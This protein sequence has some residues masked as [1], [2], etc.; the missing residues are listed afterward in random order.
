MAF[1][2]FYPEFWIYDLIQKHLISTIFTSLLMLMMAAKES[3]ANYDTISLHYKSWTSN[4]GG[5]VA[6]SLKWAHNDEWEW[7]LFSNQFLITGD[8]PL[9]GL[10]YG[11]RFPVCKRSCFISMFGQA[12]IGLSSAGPVVEFLWSLKPLWLFRIDMVTHLYFSQ[13]QPIVWSYPF[14]LGMSVPF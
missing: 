14:W 9:T 7:N 13:P 11:L 10:T 1:Q 5:Q 6:Y 8:F 12:G 2:L 3:F 4:A